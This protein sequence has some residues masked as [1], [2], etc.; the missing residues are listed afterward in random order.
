MSRDEVVANIG[1]IAKSGTREVLTQMK[2]AKSTEVADLIGQFGVGF[3]SAF[4][5]AE[6]VELVTQ[7][8]GEDAGTRWVSTG[9]GTYSVEDADRSTPG[10]SITLHLKPVDEDAGLRD[11]TEFFEIQKIVKRYSD[12]VAYP[13]KM[14]QQREN[15]VLDDDGKPVEGKTETVVEDVVINSMRPIWTRPKSEV[16]DEEYNEFYRH[17]ARD[18]NEPLDVLSLHAEGRI[19][20][21]AL[22]FLP[23]NPP[24]DLFYRD[25]Q[26]GLQLYVR[27][28]LIKESFEDLLPVYLR[29]VRGLVDSPDLPLNVSRELVQQDRH[30]T[31]IR[32]WL[33][34][35]VLDHLSSMQAS[36][37]EKYLTFWNA[38]GR[39][40]K[41]GVSA[42]S[43]N[44]DK[45]VP[46]L[47]FESSRH[48]TELTTLADYVS[49][50][51]PDQENIYYLT[52]ESRSV[53]EASPHIE[54]LRA[55]EYEVLYLVEPVDEL[56]VQSLNNFE[57][58]PLRSAAKGTVELGD[59][60]EKK[61]KKEA[62]E[63]KTK[64][65]G[66]LI[67]SLTKPL[68]EWIKEVRLTERLTSSP[69]CLVGAEHDMSP[70]FE[71]MMRQ[72]E[73]APNMGPQKRILELNPEHELIATLGA[74]YGEG[75]DES[76][77]A[78]DAYLLYGYAL[79]AEGS[80]LPD[81]ARFSRL[82]AQ[83]MTER[84]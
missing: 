3:Y 80:E 63:E 46:L 15:P 20:Y 52:A 16:K 47:R 11:F 58:K 9:D 51:K 5:V 60:D 24:F 44:R 50:M 21:Q 30:I 83:L 22:L 29:F 77:L 79:L 1:T 76:R 19:E 28:V 72:I 59:E 81:P 31:Q 23:G 78:D 71:R 82:L 33:T 61:E 55:R 38:F 56:V 66:G 32:R 12:F 14:E 10:T 26:W 8:A 37:E 13:V 39:V 6:R 53:A 62:L 2:K 48:E 49:R 70:Q 75:G 42:D 35:K 65:L 27:R 18:W 25:Q 40:L 36:D 74:R 45:L 17:I 41:E 68:D 69:A 34:R 7:R 4:M 54:G 43:D 57:E 67:E 64:S 73:G 84:G